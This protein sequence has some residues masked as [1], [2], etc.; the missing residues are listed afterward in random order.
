MQILSKEDPLY[1]KA[2][3]LE[4]KKRFMEINEKLVFEKNLYDF[5]KAG[6][7]YIDPAPFVGGWHLE[8][9]AEHL[10]AVTK[11]QIRR[12]VINVPPRTSKSSLCSVA[13][14]AWTWAQSKISP[15]SGPQVQFLSS[16]YA[17]TLS[18]R[19]S[20]KTRRLI[21]SP[22]YQKLWGDRFALTSDQNTKI[23]FEND[24][25]GYRLA[26][27]VS[28]TLTGEGG[29]CLVAGTRISTPF[30][31]KNIEEI[32]INDDVFAFDELRG[33]VVQSNVIAT[34][35]RM[36]DEIY[37]FHTAAGHS[38]RCTGNH[39]IF[40]PWREYIRADSLGIGDRVLREK[41][42][43]GSAESEMR[44]L[45]QWNSEATIRNKK[46]H[47]AAQSG[48][49]LFGDVQETTFFNK[50]LKGLFDLWR[51][52]QERIFSWKILFRSLQD[53]CPR[54]QEKE[55]RMSALWHGFYPWAQQH[56]LWPILCG[57]SAFRPYARLSE[58]QIQGVGKILKS[59]QGNGGI[60]SNSGWSQMCSLWASRQV[61]EDW[62]GAFSQ[63]VLFTG[64]SY[65]RGYAEQCAR[66]PDFNVS[67]LPQKAP[68]WDFDYI[69]SIIVDRSNQHR[70]YDIQVGRW[71]NFFAEGILVHNCIIV[72][73]AHNANEVES[74]LVRTSTLS[75]WDESLSTRLNDPETGAYVVIM[76]RLHQE[77]LT[78]HIITRDSESWTWLMLPMHH[79][80]DRHC[81]TYVKG[82][83]FWEDPRIEQDE[84]L[85]P[86]RFTPEAVEDLVRRLGPF[87]A[88]GQLEQS[89]VPRGGGIIKEEWWQTWTHPN[90]PNFD[91]VLAALDTAYTEKEENDAS[92]LTI[93]GTFRDE[94]N[95]P[96]VMLI[97]GWEDRLGIHDLVQKVMWTCT[98]N[99]LPG[100]PNPPPP[101]HF[102]NGKPR[103]KIDRL[104]VE[105]KASGISVYQE[106]HR[107]YGF[108]GKFG[109]ELFNPTKMGDKVARVY[110]I[111]HLFSEGLIYI[112]WPR[113]ENGK[114]GPYP[115]K[116]AEKILEQI[117]VFPKASH[118]D[119]VDTMSMSLRYLR[120]LGFALRTEE[121]TMD[122]AEELLY[123]GR[124]V[125][126]YEV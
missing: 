108:E 10:Q 46:G 105:S 43:I 28:G 52:Y 121:H 63:K 7:K 2:F 61:G 100:M 103:F 23:R 11:G 110:S 86:D 1:R 89:P 24:K 22:W 94:N 107:L 112:P 76:Q 120:D 18:L 82:K 54:G 119:F 37:Q 101:D 70:V 66:K 111:Q 5:L 125:P 6:W 44:G 51:T 64:A 31:L 113:D 95:N 74:E 79:D 84:L 93:W 62:K 60:D 109:I 102:L 3:L 78:G 38:F 41:W 21:E 20:V 65:K 99:P 47:Q 115:Y 118:D 30:G 98:S 97:Y 88:A 123:R 117:S 35:S 39:P 73:D 122:V 59:I 75:W 14:P 87:A 57:L 16:S 42:Q 116:W 124:T 106:L 104:I 15:C 81:I 55:K 96:K 40:S 71:S 34:K 29:Q 49:V 4:A 45:W 68:S 36:T 85:C 58:F 126:L 72:D 32:G 9:I 91:F 26:T 53:N 19:D 27:S 33:R 80:L 90:Y 8:A 25:G 56:I 92:A 13:W 114:E 48:C 69:T 77:D 12:L 67:S 17:Q 83:K 50:T